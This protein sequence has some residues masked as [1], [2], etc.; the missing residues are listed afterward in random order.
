MD[1]PDDLH[2]V[3]ASLLSA[4]LAI[5]KSATTARGTEAIDE[6][7][8][9]TWLEA[10]ITS[11]VLDH[12]ARRLRS[13]H[14]VGY[15]TIGSAGHESNA[16]VATALRTSD[17]ALLHYRSGGFYVAR[18]LQSAGACD[19][20]RDVLRGMM[21]KS[22]DQIAG[23]RHK[24]FGHHDLSIIPQ[25]STIASHLPRAVG[26]AL[27]A[28]FAPDAATTWPH[29]SVV[30]CSFGDGSLNH[31]TT[32]GALNWAAHARHR[33]ERVPI[34]FVC[35]DNGLGLSVPTPSGW[36]ATSLASRSGFSIA[37]AEGGDPIDVWNTTSTLVDEIRST[38]R[39]GILHLSTVR[40]LGHAGTDVESAYRTPSELASDLARDPILGAALVAAATTMSSPT[41]TVDWYLDLRESIEAMAWEV[42]EEPELTSAHE[43]MQPLTG[44]PSP[45]SR[46]DAANNPTDWSAPSQ[47]LQASADDPDVLTL[48]Q[49]ITRT[50]ADLLESSNDVMVFGEDVGRKGGAYG[51]T[52]GLQK[53]F[54]ERRVS[55]TLLD[56]QSVLGLA[57]GAALNGRLPI[58][59]IQYLAYLHNAEDQL[60]GE[61]ATLGFFSQRQF[62]NPM[63]VRVAGYGY[64]KGFGGHFHNDNSIAV[65]RDIPGVVIA[66]PAHPSDAGAMLR[67]CV[68]HARSS[69]DVC[70][71]LEPIARYHDTD[72]HTTGDGLWASKW[73]PATTA[74]LGRARIH[75][76]ADTRHDEGAE[77]VA[78]HPDDVTIVTFG[79]GV[80]L[81]LRAQRRLVDE[82]GIRARVVDMRWIAPFPIDDVLRAAGATGRVLVVDETRRTGGVGE[83]VVAN[84]VAAGFAGSIDRVAAQDSFVPLGAAAH[85]VLVNDD[86]IV[87]SAVALVR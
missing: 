21:A 68:E 48:A 35:E 10:Q 40:Y 24:V 23:G 41:E 65:L 15:Y 9:A 14:G 8:V 36:V 6:M 79:N 52:R 32:Q 39:P 73:E 63:V 78:P 72:L 80:W 33:G 58:P 51:L 4:I 85:L 34:L 47:A 49:T 69:G 25:T 74:T 60:R 86:Q 81:S 56:E 30:V 7:L 19:P 26:L 42:H 27:S 50:L 31:S 37:S 12:T 2:P 5:E 45:G 71:F 29:D 18:A 87:E 62:T 75:A 53:R 59:E 77:L 82:H 13:D 38:G 28:S 46:G 70:V 83:A 16:V 61:A 22:T 11:R 67:A 43:V 54:G 64:Q 3:E 55:D 44:T 57:L 1:L 84:L 17:P 66:S 20:V 76:L